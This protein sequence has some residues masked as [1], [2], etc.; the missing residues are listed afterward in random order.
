MQC[1]TLVFKTHC[2]IADKS[3]YKTLEIYRLEWND[4]DKK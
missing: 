4:H 1:I 2:K 3:L